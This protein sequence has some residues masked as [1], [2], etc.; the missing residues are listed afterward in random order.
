[1]KKYSSSLVSLLVYAGAIPAF[2]V[3]YTS[4]G[5]GTWE[6]GNDALWSPGGSG[7]SP[8]A[9]GGDNVIID[10]HTVIYNHF[11]NGGAGLAGGSTDLGVGNGNRI[12]IVNG[13]VLSQ[14]ATGSWVRIGHRDNGILNINHGRFHF[15]NSVGGG[16]NLNVGV[17]DGG[18]GTINIGDGV[19][20]AVLNLRDL[21]NGDSNDGNH[22]LNLGQHSGSVGVVNVNLNGVLEGG[23][24]ARDGSNVITRNPHIR[25]GQNSAAQSVLRVNAGG[26]VNVR[27]NLEVGAAPASVAGVAGGAHGLLHLNGQGSRVDQYDG[28]FT[29]GFDGTGEMLIENGAVYNRHNG[30]ARMDMFVGRRHGT[31]TVTIGDGGSFILNS[32]G[33]VGD[34]HV[35][36]GNGNNSG[37]QA[38]TGVL[39]IQEGGTFSNASTNWMWVGRFAGATGTINVDGG[40]FDSTDGAR[41]NIGTNGHGTFHQTSGTT[42]VVAIVLAENDGTGNFILEGGT[43]TTRSQLF[44]GGSGTGSAGTGTATGTQTGGALNV[45]GSFVIGLAS[46]HTASYDLSGGTI[47]VGGDIT[48]GESGTGALTIGAGTNVNTANGLLFVGRNDNSRGTLFVDGTLTKTGEDNAIRVGNGNTGGVDN[49]NATGLLGGNGTI[50]AAGGVWIGSNGTITAGTDATIGALSIT[51]DL[52][53]SAGGTLLA[54]FDGNNVDTLEVNGIEAVV[55]ISGAILSLEGWSGGDTGIDSRYWLIL[56]G[57]PDDIIGTFANANETGPASGYE[58]AGG[59]ITVSGQQFAVFYSA[60]YATNSFTGGNDLLLSAIPEPGTTMLILL[61]GAVGL[62]RRRR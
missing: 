20:P 22:S 39:N 31:G 44:M 29:I 56:N 51:G 17:E 38:A 16:S 41:L 54:N 35:G 34:L 10:G 6:F 49:T 8:Q 57:G 42:N 19:N 62:Q 12:D 55:D 1:M 9:G 24:I 32:G 50:D 15:S 23:A 37:D 53:F 4:T 2:A 3:D 25:V 60:N 5:S 48:V 61:A 14:T 36:A 21:I 30:P 40:T 59:F 52:G 33:N 46:N 27:G 7:G 18:Y 43:V 26:Q 58:D 13:G 47:Q 28:D 45:Q 11:N